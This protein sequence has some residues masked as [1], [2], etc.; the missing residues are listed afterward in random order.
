MT[1]KHPHYKLQFWITSIFITDET[2]GKKKIPEARTGAPLNRIAAANGRLFFDSRR[3][4]NCPPVWKWS[5]FALFSSK[6][7]ITVHL[8]MSQRENGQLPLAKPTVRS[9]IPSESWEQIKTAYASG[10]GLRE[11]RTQQPIT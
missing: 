9:R 8:N 2:V 7:S 6:T 3:F 5:E 1:E 10:I 11:S 4:K